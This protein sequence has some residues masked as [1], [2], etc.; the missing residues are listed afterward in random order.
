MMP[1]NEH[2]L[3]F[4]TKLQYLSVKWNMLQNDTI[5]CWD[6]GIF[7]INYFLMKNLGHFGPAAGAHL[8]IY[9]RPPPGPFLHHFVRRTACGWPK[10][11]PETRAYHLMPSSDELHWPG[12]FVSIPRRDSSSTMW[13]RGSVADW[14]LG[15]LQTERCHPNGYHSMRSRWTNALVNIMTSPFSGSL[16]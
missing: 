11:A 15:E 5:W 1:Q 14:L 13:G 7:R 10:G 6:R 9:I 12:N 16:W 3:R 8:V 4:I 2:L